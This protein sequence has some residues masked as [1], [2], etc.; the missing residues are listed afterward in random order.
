MDAPAHHV[1]VVIQ[2]AIA[3]ASSKNIRCTGVRRCGILQGHIT[4]GRVWECR[5]IRVRDASSIRTSF[6]QSDNLYRRTTRTTQT[7]ATQTTRTRYSTN[8]V[9]PCFDLYRRWIEGFHLPVRIARS[10]YDLDGCGGTAER[11]SFEITLRA[12]A[13][14][15]TQTPT[16]D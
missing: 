12:W 15:K 13:K 16:R 7:T 11:G 1:P 8:L 14:S 10:G 5:R 6:V 9:I 2:L 3:P 4:P